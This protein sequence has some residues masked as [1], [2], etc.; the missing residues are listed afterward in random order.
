MFRQY[1]SIH[2]GLYKSSEL[3]RE[4]KQT[5]REKLVYLSKS[6][7]AQIRGLLC[8]ASDFRPRSRGNTAVEVHGLE[9]IR[10]LDIRSKER[11]RAARQMNGES[12]SRG[13][14]LRICTNLPR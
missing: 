12:G 8:S 2:E 9:Y 13:H 14:F 7:Q 11:K 1:G 3:K 10:L 5:L 4:R 6:T